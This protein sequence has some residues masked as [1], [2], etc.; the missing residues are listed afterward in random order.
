[1]AITPP[2]VVKAGPAVTSPAV[3]ET[4]AAEIVTEAKEASAASGTKTETETAPE[5]KE[6]SKLDRAQQAADRARRASK[7]KREQQAKNDQ[8]ARQAASLQA[9]N[10]SLKSQ[11]NQIAQFQNQLKQDPYKA[12]KGLGLTYRDITA[13]VVQD[14]SIEAVVEDLRQQLNQE[15]K[16]RKSLE[17]SI[18]GQAS[19]AKESAAEKELISLV[20]EKQ[21][22]KYPNLSEQPD[23]VI[24][25]LAK[26]L[27]FE[28]ST[29][30]NP[31]TGRPAH[32]GV[33]FSQICEYLEKQYPVKKIVPPEET[34]IEEEEPTVVDGATEKKAPIEKKKSTT[35]TNKLGTTKF[36]LPKNFASLPDKQQRKILADSIRSA[37]LGK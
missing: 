33:S 12:L 20:K 15:S 35:L 25:Q 8:I 32:I 34:S 37:G 11:V 10:A 24:L 9:E 17:D 26:S 27:L 4:Q 18:N 31:D 36:T 28:L 3:T 16:A 22:T 29:K 1:M 21:K 2:E 5:T 7:W 14:G 30:T 13:R 23:R 6:P 19:A